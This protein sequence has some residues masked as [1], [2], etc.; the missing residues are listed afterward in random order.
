MAGSPALESVSAEAHPC[1]TRFC[2]TF[3]VPLSAFIVPEFG[4]AFQFAEWPNQHFVNTVKSKSFYLCGF[5]K[6]T[7]VFMKIKEKIPSLLKRLGITKTEAVNLNKSTAK[8]VLFLRAFWMITPFL[9]IPLFP[10]FHPA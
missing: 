10:G 5:A 4:S 9:T 3:S 6:N 1:I 2:R 8:T 7:G